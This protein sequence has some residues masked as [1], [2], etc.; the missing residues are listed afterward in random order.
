MIYIFSKLIYMGNIKKHFEGDE[1]FLYQ[2][3]RKVQ[4]KNWTWVCWKNIE[5]L[6]HWNICWYLAKHN[7]LF[8]QLTTGS[9][10]HYFGNRASIYLSTH[11]CDY[12]FW[13]TPHKE[14]KNHN[15]NLIVGIFVE[16]IIINYY[17]SLF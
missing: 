17:L 4:S 16:Y 7:T 15:S 1:L 3:S 14:K 9:A 8:N 6:Y 2:L 12:Q 11:P 5:M 13:C 10:W